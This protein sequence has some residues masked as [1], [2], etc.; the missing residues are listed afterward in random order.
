VIAAA[1]ADPS[2]LVLCH[3]F[4]SITS[5]TARLRDAKALSIWHARHTKCLAEV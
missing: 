5:V 4:L 2:L 3:T 1:T